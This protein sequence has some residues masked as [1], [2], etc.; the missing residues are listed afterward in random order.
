MSLR[1]AS[2]MNTIRNVKTKL[3][4]SLPCKRAVMHIPSF[5][6]LSKEGIPFTV[7]MFMECEIPIHLYLFRSRR[8]VND[9]K[10][11][12]KAKIIEECSSKSA[13][14]L[15]DH[16]GM[17]MNIS[18]SMEEYITNYKLSFLD[19]TDFK[20]QRHIQNDFN[21]LLEIK[22]KVKK[23]E[24][25]NEKEIGNLKYE[26]EQKLKNHQ[27]LLN[28]SLEREL[29]EEQVIKSLISKSK[30]ISEGDLCFLL[31]NQL[32]QHFKELQANSITSSSYIKRN[33]SH[34]SAKYSEEDYED[35]MKRINFYDNEILYSTEEILED[36]KK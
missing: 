18:K 36:E 33:E 34:S 20:T 7:S 8:K 13:T 19:I 27:I 28:S 25:K 22:E 31:K 21:K 14:K 5:S 2:M 11:F 6:V 15:D 3:T 16:Q 9:M 4:L 35:L 24:Q 1:T 12:I 29:M 23:I 17:K 30:D 26:L 32:I 10:D